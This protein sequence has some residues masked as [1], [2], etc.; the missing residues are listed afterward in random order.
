MKKVLKNP[1]KYRIPDYPYLEYFEGKIRSANI[2]TEEPKDSDGYIHINRLR[3][4]YQG[5][6]C[7]FFAGDFNNSQTGQ[8]TDIT[9]SI[10]SNVEGSKK[11]FIIPDANVDN[12]FKMDESY[13]SEDNTDFIFN[14][15]KLFSSDS[16]LIISIFDDLSICYIEDNNLVGEIQWD[17]Y[18]SAV[19]QK[20]LS[21]IPFI[22]GT[23]NPLI[24]SNDLTIYY[25]S[26][27]CT[28]GCL[29][30]NISKI[31]SSDP[32]IPTEESFLVIFESSEGL[33]SNIQTP[34]G[35]TLEVN[36]LGVVTMEEIEYDKYVLT[37]D[38]YY[39]LTCNFNFVPEAV[40]GSNFLHFGYGNKDNDS[41]CSLQPIPNLVMEDVQISDF[42]L[43]G[44]S[45][46]DSGSYMIYNQATQEY[47]LDRSYIGKSIGHCAY[48]PLGKDSSSY[49]FKFIVGSING[50]ADPLPTLQITFPH[51]VSEF[52]VVSNNG[53]KV[54]NL[55]NQ[56][57]LDIPLEEEVQS[58][59][60]CCNYIEV[61]HNGLSAEYEGG[62]SIFN[63]NIIGSGV[64][65]NIVKIYSSNRDFIKTSDTSFN[66]TSSTT[67]N[68]GGSINLLIHT[69]KISNFIRII[70]T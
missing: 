9:L 5:N 29:D 64:I 34:N 10:S 51:S 7:Y 4:F 55:T 23:F 36:K 28:H 39:P 42:N 33:P 67:G 32:V 50:E 3:F 47:T 35:L 12:P 16:G 37:E 54:G 65:N 56:S 11:N 8:S 48:Y 62:E 18:T 41:Y 26:Y 70:L 17:Q 20:Y 68:S 43:I 57:T 45:V 25:D 63:L 22:N 31:E 6:Q 13:V 30:L 21:I 27:T 69:D 49:K 14:G 66:I 59:Y 40:E 58:N 1:E 60:G 38:D 52:Y 24:F 2:G 19:N 53:T 61:T 44:N 46:Y 15:D